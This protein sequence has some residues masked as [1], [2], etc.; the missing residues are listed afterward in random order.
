MAREARPSIDFGAGWYDAVGAGMRV[1]Q[2][3][4]HMHFKRSPLLVCCGLMWNCGSQR[5]SPMAY[6]QSLVSRCGMYMCS[7]QHRKIGTLAGSA[8]GFHCNLYSHLFTQ[9][10]GRHAA[11]TPAAPARRRRHRPPPGRRS[12]LRARSAPSLASIT[13]DW[14]DLR[15][16]GNIFSLFNDLV[17][18]AQIVDCSLLPRRPHATSRE[19]S[20][21]EIV[22]PYANR[23]GARA[24]SAKL[25]FTQ[26]SSTPLILRA[27]P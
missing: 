14:T 21:G 3:V 1:C 4:A 27:I 15:R 18:S 26:H 20:I 22:S 25:E 12:G 19:C 2:R 5:E 8:A 9:H 11:P 23:R 10:H 16:A 6:V 7:S 24:K 13:A 17:L